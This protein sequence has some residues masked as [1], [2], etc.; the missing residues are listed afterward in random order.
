M[1]IATL[2][3]AVLLKSLYTQI[4][5]QCFYFASVRSSSRPSFSPSWFSALLSLVSDGDFTLAVT[6]AVFVCSLRN[7]WA[8][9][10]SSCL[11][12]AWS[13]PRGAFEPGPPP[14]PAPPPPG[15]AE[16]EPVLPRDWLPCCCCC[17]IMPCWWELGALKRDC[18]LLGPPRGPPA[19]MFPWALEFAWAW[20]CCAAWACIP[21]SS[22]A[23]IR[24][25]AAA[26]RMSTHTIILDFSWAKEWNATVMHT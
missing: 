15:I 5:L 20:A 1:Y 10:R 13:P 8:Y 6:V 4:L 7:L 9:C 22:C 18:W 3:R 26:G 17:P 12:F 24:A 14:P 21:I 16:L 2:L 19:P 11:C 23:C 25:P